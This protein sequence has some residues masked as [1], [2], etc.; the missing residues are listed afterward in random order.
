MKVHSWTWP[1][2]KIPWPWLLNAPIK[3]SAMGLSV[4]FTVDLSICNTAESISRMM[5]S[6]ICI[7]HCLK[8]THNVHLSQYMASIL[9]LL[10]NICACYSLTLTEVSYVHHVVHVWESPGWKRSY[11][12]RPTTSVGERK[13]ETGFSLETHTRS[14]WLNTLYFGHAFYFSFLNSIQKSSEIYAFRKEILQT[15]VGN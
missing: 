5:E 10:G 4:T 3:V 9:T 6:I 7:F 14:G 15:A 1:Q 13:G 11:L 12:C 8:I 2:L